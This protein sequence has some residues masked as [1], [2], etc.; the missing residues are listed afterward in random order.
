MKLV[1]LL[2]VDSDGNAYITGTTLSLDFPTIPG[3]YDTTYADEDVFVAKLSP[4]LTI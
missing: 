3:A 4:L 2:L 1:L